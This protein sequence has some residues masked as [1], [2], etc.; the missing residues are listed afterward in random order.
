LTLTN[1]FSFQLLFGSSLLLLLLL[2]PL[3]FIE[4]KVQIKQKRTRQNIYNF[5]KWI[6]IG[7]KRKRFSY[8]YLFFLLSVTTSTP[9]TPFTTSKRDWNERR[10]WFNVSFVEASIKFP[11]EFATSVLAN[12]KNMYRI[13][14]RGN[15]S[16]KKNIKPVCS[17]SAQICRFCS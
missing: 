3:Y 17:I 12:K 16:Q 13:G 9:T 6:K 15:S 10:K 4:S 14:K 7:R 2:F 8:Y 1:N 11:K 5:P